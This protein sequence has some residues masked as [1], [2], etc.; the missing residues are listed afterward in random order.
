[1]TDGGKD[2]CGWVRASRLHPNGK[3][4]KALESIGVGVIYEESEHETLDDM[5]RSRRPGDTV[6]VTSLSRLARTKEGI[7]IAIDRLRER[8]CVI[9]ETTTGR[10]SDRL[11]DCPHM[12]MDAVSDIAQD[13]RALPSKLAAEFGR[14]GAL[15]TAAKKQAERTPESEAK[16]I[17]RGNPDKTNREVLDM[18][19][20]WTERAAYRHLGPRKR[21]AG[22]PRVKR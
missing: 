11:E 16:L 9:V 18:L 10:R 20:G 14:R 7:L 6:Y 5:I 22:R 17:W 3:Q 13:N 12:I 1:M 21:E 2:K 15:A 19:T 4:R 8:G